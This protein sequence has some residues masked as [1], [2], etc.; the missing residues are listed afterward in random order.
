MLQ[1]SFVTAFEDRMKADIARELNLHSHAQK[2][3]VDYSTDNG[4]LIELKLNKMYARKGQD[5]LI[6]SKNQYGIIRNKY[7]GKGSSKQVTLAASSNQHPT[8]SYLFVGYA[9]D[10]PV[11]SAEKVDDVIDAM[12]I[13]K[14]LLMDHNLVPVLGHTGEESRFFRMSPKVLDK[15]IA[16]SKTDFPSRLTV[17][18]GKVKLLGFPT[19]L[20][21]VGSEYVS[22]LARSIF[23]GY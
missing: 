9:T 20:T 23:G 8:F 3:N 11:S 19:E 14:A 13:Q 1:Q 15:V 10:K 22:K 6:A 21:V 2:R 17:E 18:S 5:R 16:E 7:L 12:N 4:D